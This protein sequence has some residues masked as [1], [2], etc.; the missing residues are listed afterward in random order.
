MK[1]T[2]TTNKCNVQEEKLKVIKCGIYKKCDR[3][4]P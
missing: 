2:R 3:K 4:E 1:E